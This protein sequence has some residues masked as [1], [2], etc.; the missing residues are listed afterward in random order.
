MGGAFGGTA[1][2]GGGG[3]A[4]LGG[5]IFNDSGNVTVRNSTF[6]GNAATGGTGATAPNGQGRGA[7]VFARDGSTKIY[8][9]TISGHA[10][11]DGAIIIFGT[12]SNPAPTGSFI[13][14]N[15]IVAN[16]GSS[17]CL[18]ISSAGTPTVATAGSGNL[19][20]NNATGNFSCPGVVS[21]AAPA[22]GPLQINAPGNTPTMA[23]Q[24]TS[25]AFNAGDNAA[26][27]ATDQRGVI[28]PQALLCDIGAFEAEVADLSIAKACHARAIDG[29]IDEDVIYAGQQWI[30]DIT[31]NNPS[32]VAV[33]DFSIT[34]T[35][36]INLTFVAHTATA[37]AS[38]GGAP[39]VCGPIPTVG[40][41]D[42]TCTGLDVAARRSV[43]FQMAFV[44]DFDFVALAPTGELPIVNRVCIDDVNGIVGSVF[45]PNLTNNCA[46]ETDIVKDLADLRITKYV[47]PFGTVR[48]GQIFTY[49]IF[50]DNLGPSAARRAVI[51]DT[52]LSSGNVTI[53]SCAFSVSQGGGAITQFTCTTGNL[54]STQFGSDIGTFA[55]SLVEPLTPDSQGRLR[56]SF[57]LVA[58]QD[59]KVTN[60]ARVTSLTP[61]P[62]MS[63]NFTETFLAVTGVT[64]LVLTKQATGEEQQ[65]NQPGLIFNNAIFGQAFPTAPNYFVSIR[66]TAGRRIEYLLT[67][68]NTGPSRAE[69]VVLQDRLPAGVQ[70]YQG[71]V[72]ATMDPAGA[73]PLVNLPA[74]TCTTGTP[75]DPL[76]KLACALGTM[77][78]GDVA[79]LRF[80]VVTDSTLPAGAVLENDALVTADTFELNT[81]DNLRFTQNTV[82]SAA[83][84]SL[85]KSNMG[86]VV[87]GVNPLT[88]ELIVTDTANAVTAGMLL[89]YQLSATNNGP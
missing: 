46:A 30:C 61:D 62:D 23:I 24:N 69:R 26:C 81:T 58:N 48:A 53:Q 79:T 49:T 57:R 12:S 6:S 89:R 72:V 4:G 14:R 29:R 74:G 78:V 13:I 70:I 41:G 8:N 59:I 3:G 43:S 75:G 60:T 68:S 36:P 25:P 64:N 65:T 56:A 11:A 82:L 31:I 44:V 35:L 40:P 22:L 77:Q 88:G 10:G 16:N 20:V 45:D 66:A 55:T 18:V 54:V 73:A 34:D 63:N 28:R 39:G 84:M 21:T 33:T 1:A 67:V 2:S 83:D 17:D 37:D 51:S 38:T 76:D 27:L 32:G 5:A 7:A 86:E 47:E 87:T 50:V 9:S 85:T 52:L 71:S 80:Q 15:S 19:I 42:V